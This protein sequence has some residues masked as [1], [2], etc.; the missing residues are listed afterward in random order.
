MGKRIIPSPGCEGLQ[1]IYIEDSGGSLVHVKESVATY[2]NLP[3]T[4][5][6]ENDLR[7]TR[8]TDHMHT[9]TIASASGILANWLDLG[10]ISSIDWSA[11]TNKPTSSV[12]DIDDAVA[13]KHTQGTDQKLDDG[14]VNEVT[15]ANAKDA[16]DKKHS[17]NTDTGTN[18][19]TFAIDSVKV[20]DESGIFAA[21]NNADDDYVIM[22]AKD[23]VN[24]NDLATK[25]WIASLYATIVDV[26]KN[27]DN[28]VVNGFRIAINGALTIYNMIDGIVDEYEDES[29]IDTVASIN[30]SYDATDDFYKPS[31][32]V[33]ISD[34]PYAHFKCNDDAANTTATDNGTGANNGVASVNTSSLSVAGKINDAFNFIGSTYVTID[35]L[36]ADIRTDTTGSFIGWIKTSGSGALFAL[37]NTTGAS[38]YFQIGVSAGKI[39][40]WIYTGSWV[41][42]VKSTTSVNT[43]EWVHIAIVQNGTEVKIYINGND[44]ILNYTDQTNKGGWIDD[45]QATTGGQIGVSRNSAGSNETYYTGQMDDIRYYQ[46][47]VLSSVD[48][49]AIYNDGNGTEDKNPLS[50]LD[51]MTLISENVS[52]EVD[53][54]GAR[55]VI[56]EEDVSS[57]ALNTDLKA[58]AS[59]DDGATWAQIT[60]ENEG[61]YDASKRIL[62]G[63]ADLAVSGIG[64][65]TDMV[66]KLTTHNEKN[67]KIHATSLRWD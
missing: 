51:N 23:P 44:D 11:V 31:G 47:V 66:Y 25:I 64:A 15:A 24:D 22:R 54:D 19:D 4:G 7:I 26:V 38:R 33:P 49:G 29:G 53:P 60:L 57:I 20:K 55:I 50:A 32:G 52:A 63:N 28:I 18:S 35:A 39:R 30:E 21:R 45:A 61:D 14:G 36:E 16:V 48:V 9:W 5:N 6:T 3:I 40:F 62:V 56:L 42:D 8:D 17:Q 58:Y 46:N 13:K 43:G 67:L 59:K 1:F 10:P 41:I 37:S 27:L 2:N 34:D 12:A 65:G